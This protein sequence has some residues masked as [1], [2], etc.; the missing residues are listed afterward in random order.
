MMSQTL[1]ITLALTVALTALFAT[2]TPSQ[3]DAKPRWT[4]TTVRV[5]DQIKH[6]RRI[7]ANRARVRNY[8]RSTRR[9]RVLPNSRT[10][11]RVAPTSTFWR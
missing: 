7:H 5:H 3:A 8:W 10:H 4:A 1:R 2:I 11:N 6:Q 9:S